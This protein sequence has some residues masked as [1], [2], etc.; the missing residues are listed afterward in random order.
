MYVCACSRPFVFAGS[1]SFKRFH[2]VEDNVL[3][4]LHYYII[5]FLIMLYV[6]VLLMVDFMKNVKYSK[7]VI[8]NSI[9]LFYL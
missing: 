6:V 3:G 9:L 4:I 1:K 2:I 7:K 5:S 8:L